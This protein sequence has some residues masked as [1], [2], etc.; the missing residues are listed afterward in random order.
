MRHNLFNNGHTCLPRDSLIKTAAGFLGCSVDDAEISAD[1]L[2]ENK[3]IVSDTVFA[4]EML[5]D[6]E[7]YEA[8]RS[9]AE[10]IRFIEKY[11]GK[12][13]PD[14][15]EL[16]HIPYGIIHFPNSIFC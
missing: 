13:F 16:H 10:Q 1:F 9:S 8:E 11:A 3:R 5:F 14:M 4:R 15:E 12:A 6:P 2:I 7:M